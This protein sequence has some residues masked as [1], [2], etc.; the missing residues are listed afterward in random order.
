MVF[1]LF[2]YCVTVKTIYS[3]T[4]INRSVG[5]LL[6]FQQN[7]PQ[8]RQKKSDTENNKVAAI[9]KTMKLPGDKYN[10]VLESK[11]LTLNLKNWAIVIFVL[12]SHISCQTL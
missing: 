1:D 2:S 8:N 6:E 12:N 11:V 7:D 10:L 9:L 3:V 5:S 4:K